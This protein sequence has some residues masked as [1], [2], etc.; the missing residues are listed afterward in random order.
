MESLDL[1]DMV[2]DEVEYKNLDQ[3]VID[4]AVRYIRDSNRLMQMLD[5]V[6]EEAISRCT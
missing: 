1:R 4:K 6:V 2:A 5:M 3:S